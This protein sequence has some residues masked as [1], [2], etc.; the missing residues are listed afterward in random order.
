MATSTAAPV[1]VNAAPVNRATRYAT[2]VPN[3]IT[4]PP[5]VGVPTF[6][7]W[8]WCASGPSPYHA[9][10]MRWPNP[11]ARNSRMTT[12]VVVS[13]MISPT[14]AAMRIEVTGS[15]PCSRSCCSPW[16]PSSQGLRQPLQAVHPRRLH[17]HEVAVVRHLA[18]RLGRRGAVGDLHDVVAVYALAQRRAGD[19]PG[20]GTHRDQLLDAQPRDQLADVVVLL[21][22]RVTQLRHSAEHR[23]APPAAR[24]PPRRL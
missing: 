22:R 1:A 9:S 21:G 6:P 3:R 16:T 4:T 12:G 14:A 2:H 15:H 8:P 20:V 17:Q 11:H 13:V 18:H 7:R 24:H 19:G 10:R 23:D 5:M